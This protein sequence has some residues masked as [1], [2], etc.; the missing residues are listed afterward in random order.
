MRPFIAIDFEA[1]C[2]PCHGRSFPIEVGIASGSGESRSWLIRPHA[3]WANWS[4]T[5]EAER[6]HGI[7]RAQ[8]ETDG[9][10]VDHVLAELEQA[11][12]RNRV[13]ADNYLDGIW[14][15]TLCSAARTGASFRI[16]HLRQIVD[17]LD[18]GALEVQDAMEAADRAVPKRHRAASDALWIATVA[19]DLHRRAL[20]RSHADSIRRAENDDGLPLRVAG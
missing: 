7:S 5:E 2:L 9:V 16:D 15:G 20:L 1:S 10:P 17:E 12:G 18:A 3:D 4:W 19:D 6:L 13:L 11:V 8:L 14:L